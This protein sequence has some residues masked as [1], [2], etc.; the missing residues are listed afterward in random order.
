V[1]NAAAAV[2]H[3]LAGILALDAP[4]ASADAG[5]VSTPAITDFSVVFPLTS[6]RE[7][8]GVSASKAIV[9]VR[10]SASVATGGSFVVIE[11]A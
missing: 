1:Q 10:P 3:D 6:S 9:P 4:A 2:D 7:L 8:F 5:K 11:P